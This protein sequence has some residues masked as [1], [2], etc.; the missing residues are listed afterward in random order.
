MS[1]IEERVPRARTH[2]TA[3]AS[4]AAN[5]SDQARVPRPRRLR[6]IAP[7]LGE[8]GMDMAVGPQFEYNTDIYDRIAGII[9]HAIK[10]D[11]R[12]ELMHLI[13]PSLYGTDHSGI[14]DES[15]FRIYIYHFLKGDGD[16][17]KQNPRAG[18][19]WD[20]NPFR[21][22]EKPT[23]PPDM[24]GSSRSPRKSDSSLVANLSTPIA[25]LLVDLKMMHDDM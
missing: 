10:S 15:V 24:S 23:E 4:P 16:E 11:K 19:L 6:L 5:V 25:N 13:S 14:I 8:P 1:Q 9:T 12:H 7:M 20:Y 2:S 18:S 3:F 21:R 22:E 17:S